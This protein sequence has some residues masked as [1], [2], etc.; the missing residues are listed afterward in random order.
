MVATV[1]S[2]PSK[3]E[4]V[5][6]L[7]RQ[8]LFKRIATVDDIGEAVALF[9]ADGSRWVTAQDVMLTGGGGTML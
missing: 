3:R 6:E 5:D 8:S 1:L 7:I 9:V 2:D 4:F